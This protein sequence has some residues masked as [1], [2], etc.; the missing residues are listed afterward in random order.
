MQHLHAVASNN[1]TCTHVLRRLQTYQL[2]KICCVP[3]LAMTAHLRSAY[4]N[5]KAWDTYGTNAWWAR[6]FADPSLACELIPLR[7][8]QAGLFCPAE[9][10]S[11]DVAA[12][13]VV[14]THGNRSSTISAAECDKA[15]AAFKVRR[16]RMRASHH[17]SYIKHLNCGGNRDCGFCNGVNAHLCKLFCVHVRP[18]IISGAHQAACRRQK[19]G[20]RLHHHPPTFTS[21]LAPPAPTCSSQAF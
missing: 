4:Q 7:L 15:F 6:V 10:T 19:Q 9:T 17:T 20:R 3:A 18:I 12:G 16:M 5:Y 11:A 14:L 1:C 8:H 2:C 13:I 21:R